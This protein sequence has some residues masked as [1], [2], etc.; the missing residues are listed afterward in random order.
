VRAL[1]VQR[2]REH[3]VALSPRLQV[4]KRRTVTLRGDA[5]R[6]AVGAMV[7][8]QRQAHLHT[9]RGTTARQSPGLARHSQRGAGGAVSKRACPISTG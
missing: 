2:A 1:R 6:R 4:D 3:L 7:P 8:E 5:L 9:P